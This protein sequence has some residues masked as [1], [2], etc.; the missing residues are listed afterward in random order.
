ML[1][2]NIHGLRSSLAGAFVILLAGCATEPGMT[3]AQ[4]DASSKAANSVGLTG[5]PSFVLGRA[6]GDAVD[7]VAIV[8]AQPY[9]VFAARIDAA[10][11]APLAPAAH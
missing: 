2:P 5:T 10:L 6:S 3:R 7:G 1:L 11:K 9:D 4:G 8:G